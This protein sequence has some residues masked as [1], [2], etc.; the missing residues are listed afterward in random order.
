MKKEIERKFLIKDIITLLNK[1]WKNKNY[2]NYDICQVYFSD[3]ARLRVEV[4]KPPFEREVHYYFT[5]KVGDTLSREEFSFEIPV[6]EGKKLMD[7][8]M[9]NKNKVIK[10]RYIYEY[11]SRQWEI[12]VFHEENFGLN[13]AEIELESEDEKFDIPEEIGEEVTYDKKYYNSNLAKNPYS[14]WENKNG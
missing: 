5:I 7:K 14:T 6:E 9:D 4:K 8:L 2:I 3:D 1:I 13:I 12:D 10:S 11:N